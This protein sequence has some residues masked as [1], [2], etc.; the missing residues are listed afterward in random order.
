MRVRANARVA[1]PIGEADVVAAGHMHAHAYTHIK[2]LGQH[3]N[4]CESRRY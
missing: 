4:P 1:G 2:F 3:D